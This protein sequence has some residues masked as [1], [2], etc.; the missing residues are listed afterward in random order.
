MSVMLLKHCVSTSVTPECLS[1]TIA[2]KFSTGWAVGVMKSV[3][4]KKSLP[5]QFA[6][7]YKSE[8][9]CWTPKLNRVDYGVHKYW[10]PLAVVK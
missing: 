10:V 1:K 7:K 3:E 2:Q 6:V 5:G 8:T 9:Y 4:K